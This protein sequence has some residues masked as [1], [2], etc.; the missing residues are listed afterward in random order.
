MARWSRR[1]DFD[2]DLLDKIEICI[3]AFALHSN[4]S[5]IFCSSYQL[6]SFISLPCHFV[7]HVNLFF[8][9]LLFFHKNTQSTHWF[10]SSILTAIFKISFFSHSCRSFN[11]YFY[12]PNKTILM[13]FIQND[14]H[15]LVF[16]TGFT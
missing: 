12:A 9:L 13:R 16:A 14:V 8:F 10:C 7:R 1:C 2:M 5:N 11:E 6:N 4:V 3:I 15:H